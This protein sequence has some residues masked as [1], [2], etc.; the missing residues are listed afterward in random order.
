MN[1]TFSNSKFTALL[2]IILNA[3]VNVLQ[4]TL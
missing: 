2:Y 4:K 1:E 3:S